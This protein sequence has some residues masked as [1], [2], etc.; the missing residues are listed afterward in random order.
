M[1]ELIG[2]V[3]PCFTTRFVD[4]LLLS[5]D[6]DGSPQCLPRKS[7]HCLFEGIITSSLNYTMHYN[8]Q[9]FL[10]K[11]SEA[12]R[13][14]KSPKKSGLEPHGTITWTIEIMITALFEA[15][16]HLL[17]NFFHCIVP[18]LGHTQGANSPFLYSWRIRQVRTHAHF[19]PRFSA[20][21]WSF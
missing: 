4:Q 16:R 5:F 8:E 20:L 17:E 15:S 12:H 2:S 6:C 18:W 14:E 1:K 19:D 9:N 21:I 7:E 3:T 13:H 10:D 11:C